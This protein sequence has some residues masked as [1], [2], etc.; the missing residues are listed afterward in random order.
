MSKSDRIDLGLGI[1]D[2]CREPGK[3]YTQEEIAAWAGCSEAAVGQIEAKALAKLR[4]A[5]QRAKVELEPSP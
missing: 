5:L 3:C 4:R 2:A 1:L